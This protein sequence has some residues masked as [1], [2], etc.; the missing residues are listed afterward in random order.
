METNSPMT[1]PPPRRQQSGFTLI[2]LLVAIAILGILGTVVIQEIWNYVD[3]ARQEGTHAK[4]KTVY[5]QVMMFRRNNHRYPSGDL[6]ELV[7]PDPRNL[8]NPYLGEEDLLDAWGNPLQLIELDTGR[9]AVVSYGD[10]GEEDGWDMDLGL[11]MD[12]YSDRPLLPPLN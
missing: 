3:K 5:D 6:T 8:N 11:A 9:F 10:G 12:I 7:E 4:V 1:P 2:E